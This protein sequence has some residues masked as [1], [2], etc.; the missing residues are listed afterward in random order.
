MSIQVQIS[1]LEHGHAQRLLEAAAHHHQ[2]LD[3]ETQRLRESQLQ[4]QTVLESRE[5]AHQQ[6]VRGLEGQVRY[7]PG[8]LVVLVLPA[9]IKEKPPHPHVFFCASQLQT[10]REQLELEAR[11]QLGPLPSRGAQ[12]QTLGGSTSADTSTSGGGAMALGTMLALAGPLPPPARSS[13]MC[14]EDYINLRQ[15]STTTNNECFV[16]EQHGRAKLF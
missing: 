9:K 11:R 12:A 10:L 4:A 3:L 14:G 7:L 2:E 15:N 1:Q 6:R 8:G 5:K 16:Y 13:H